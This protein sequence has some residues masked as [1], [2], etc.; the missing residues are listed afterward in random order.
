MTKTVHWKILHSMVQLSGHTSWGPRDI[1]VSPF[2]YCGRIL[3]GFGQLAQNSEGF[4]S[5]PPVLDPLFGCS[6]Q[7]FN[8]FARTWSRGLSLDVGLCDPCCYPSIDSERWQKHSQTIRY[9]SDPTICESAPP[10][11]ENPLKWRAR[12]AGATA[13]G[14]PL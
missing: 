10:Q 9:R 12:S 5:H 1:H 3:P 13:P 8:F 11:P 14:R 7:I 6:V 4:C 2:D